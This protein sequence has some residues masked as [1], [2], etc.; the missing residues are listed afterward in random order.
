[1]PASMKAKEKYAMALDEAWKHH[2]YCESHEPGAVAMGYSSNCTPLT[3]PSVS[4]PN[5]ML[6]TSH[7]S[8][9]SDVV[10][11][12]TRRTSHS[13]QGSGNGRIKT[14]WKNIVSP[15]AY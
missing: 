15:P 6:T 4:D 9:G 7:P 12:V 3:P 8:G 13:S 14:L 2:N 1:M 11:C 10:N 5:R